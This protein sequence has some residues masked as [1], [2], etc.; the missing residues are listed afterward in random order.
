ML[1]NKDKPLVTMSNSTQ[2]YFPYSNILYS[3]QCVGDCQYTYMICING[4]K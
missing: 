1:I 2:N 3:D 4:Y